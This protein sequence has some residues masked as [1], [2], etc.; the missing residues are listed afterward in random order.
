M[1]SIVNDHVFP[2]LDLDLPL[3]ITAADIAPEIPAPET[4]QDSASVPE[5]PLV[6][7]N[8]REA[9]LCEDD[10]APTP[11]SAS[12]SRTPGSDTNRR[13]DTLVRKSRSRRVRTGCLTCRERHLKCDEALHRC[14]NCRKSGRI[15]R[16][17]V[18][19]NF[20]DTQ[21]VAPP[22]DLTPSSGNRV[23]FRDESRHIASEYVG[24]F[25]RYPPPQA[26]LSVGKNSLVSP[27]S[28]SRYNMRI[29]LST[30]PGGGV[31]HAESMNCSPNG[32]A[33]LIP[34]Q[35]L[36]RCASYSPFKSA[37]QKR[38]VW[39]ISD[40]EEAFLM[41]AFVDEVAPWMDSTDE[42]KHFTEILPFYT[43]SEPMLQKAFM[44]CGARHVFHVNPSYGEEKASYFYDLATQSLLSHLR[45]PDRDSAL[46][47]TV[48]VILNTYELMCS[49]LMLAP[50][51]MNH[52][53]GAR[54][55][56]KEC[57]WDATSQGLGGACF[58][59]NI[60][61]ELL[62]CVHFNWALAWDPDTWGVDTN[63]EQDQTDKTNVAGSEEMWTH[64]MVYICAKIA[65]FRSS[66]SHVHGVEHSP[67]QIQKQYRDWCVYNEWCDHWAKAV[68]RSMVPLSYLQPWQTN[69]KSVFPEIWLIKRSAIVAQLFYHTARILLTKVNPVESE[70]SPE[71]QSMQQSHVHD[72]CGI[73]VHIKDGGISSL[74]IR[75]LAVA[76]ACLST[77][78]AQEEILGTVDRIIRETGCRAEHIKDELQEAWGWTSVHHEVDTLF[79]DQAFNPDPSSTLLKMPPVVV[80]PLMAFAD[81]SLEN[82]P[83]QGYYVAPNQFSH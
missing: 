37:K 7:A 63:M 8:L 64:R 10:D 2:L 54:A 61:M 70:F 72:I 53:A 27:P 3:D 82:Y 30:Q 77:R 28:S 36:D 51:G 46:C 20:I 76:A 22:H 75:F 18:R 50:H 83:Y 60:S 73:V 13:S 1:A 15:C 41:R 65:N 16:R 43:L 52:T 4:N 6:D 31:S 40:P 5:T 21:V 62:N 59:L 48:A 11:N 38:T 57:R 81:F 12:T 78:D 25:E 39:A 49:K 66:V 26:D 58:W 47:A 45:D 9:G 34:H 44:A 24:G 23:T 74:C 19:L 17:G 79:N 33:H 14:Q 35:V 32:H 80:N 56:I 71:M 55:L 42:M 29:V 68:P 67:M 69:S